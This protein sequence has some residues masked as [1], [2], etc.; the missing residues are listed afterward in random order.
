M[1]YWTEIRL[2]Y[3]KGVVGVVAIVLAFAL[4]VLCGCSTYQV[5]Y[6][7]SDGVISI[8]LDESVPP[9]GKSIREGKVTV[10]YES[11]GEKWSIDVGANADTDATGTGAWIERMID[12]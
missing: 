2:S 10:T 3:L 9:Y 11:D 1:I 5:N 8:D 6:S 4:G 7:E 12:K